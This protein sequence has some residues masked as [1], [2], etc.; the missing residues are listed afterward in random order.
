MAAGFA[1]ILYAELILFYDF[2]KKRF[3]RLLRIF[4]WI[5]MIIST[6]CTNEVFY[7]K[8]DLE[9]MIR[10]SSQIREAD[11]ENQYFILFLSKTNHFYEFRWRVLGAMKSLNY[12][13]EILNVIRKSI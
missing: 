11:L 13:E 4:V 3:R 10:A 2:F 1:Q 7:K 9:E 12:K 6:I 5:G 8:I